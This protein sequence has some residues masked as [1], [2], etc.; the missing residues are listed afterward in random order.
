LVFS[1]M[2]RQGFTYDQTEEGSGVRRATIK[3]WRK[4]N[5]PGLESIEAVLGFLGWGFVPVP[6]L[7]AL[8]PA[9]AGDLTALALRANSDI[10]TTF[11][12]LVAVGVEQALVNMTIAEKRAVVEARAA[13]Y[14]A[15]DNI[16][17]RRASGL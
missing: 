17:R 4:K 3:A 6:S 13:G 8:P 14:A 10:P 1:E 16:K 5:A 11:A 9:F 15:N 12:A 7:Q 2:A